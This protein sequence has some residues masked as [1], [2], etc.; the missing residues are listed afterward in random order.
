MKRIAVVTCNLSLAVATS[1]LRIEMCN[2]MSSCA[3]K[4]RG[5]E[6]SC[7]LLISC[8]AIL[9]ITPT[10]GIFATY[11]GFSRVEI[12]KQKRLTCGT[13]LQGTWSAS[14]FKWNLSSVQLEWR[15]SPSTPS[16]TLDR[17][18]QTNDASHYLTLLQNKRIVFVGDSLAR[19]FYN[20]F[21]DVLLPGLLNSIC[22]YFLYEW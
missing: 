17:W 12:F 19:N 1:Y 7:H 8:I 22:P 2:E 13:E 18:E 4:L 10:I 11:S 16:C 5:K 6:S 3:T 15:F 9:L 14:N 20:S 21:I